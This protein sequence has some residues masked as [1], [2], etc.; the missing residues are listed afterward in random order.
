VNTSNVAQVLGAFVL[1]V[2]VLVVIFLVLREFWC[3]YWK[4]NKLISLQEE[5]NRL[6]RASLQV[7]GISEDAERL[8]FIQEEV[9]P[10]CR[11]S[12]KTRNAWSSYKRKSCHRIPDFTS[13]T[14]PLMPRPAWKRKPSRP[15]LSVRTAGRLPHPNSSTAKYV[16]SCWGRRDSAS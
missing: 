1:Y 6:L 3:W 8:E 11:A 2:A 14:A 16:V 9:V 13:A 7:Q 12:A 5:T 15:Q 10:R 4:I